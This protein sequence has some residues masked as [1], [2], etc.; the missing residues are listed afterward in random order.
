ML[1]VNG[2]L[3]NAMLGGMLG[4]SL[5][6]SVMDYQSLASARIDAFD[7]MGALATRANLIGVTYDSILT[8]N[9]KVSDIIAAAPSAQQTDNGAS[10]ATTALSTISQAVTSFSTKITPASLIDLGPYNDRTVGQTSPFPPPPPRNN[11]EN[12]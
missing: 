2:G 8:S 11:S 5:S 1:S 9:L 6:L 3:I 12:D 4:T 10:S 7:F